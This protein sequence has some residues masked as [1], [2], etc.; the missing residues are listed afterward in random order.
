[1]RGRRGV[2]H[3]GVR[4]PPVVLGPL[5]MG[6]ETEPLLPPDK[7]PVEEPPLPTEPPWAP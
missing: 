6:I 3:L 5:C 1:M 2:G 4:R 7:V